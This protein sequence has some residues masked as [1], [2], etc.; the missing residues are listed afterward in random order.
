M[1][2]T[3]TLTD[4]GR[5]GISVKEYRR[6]VEETGSIRGAANEL[7]VSYSTAY[8]AC[9]RHEIYVP[10]LDGAPGQDPDQS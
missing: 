7:G 4:G 10:T 6:A 2:D 8:G 3:E 1:S 5:K 9:K